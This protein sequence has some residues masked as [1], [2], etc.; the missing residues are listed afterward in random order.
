MYLMVDTTYKQA[1]ESFELN[2]NDTIH[3]GSIFSWALHSVKEWSVYCRVVPLST[4]VVNC[5]KDRQPTEVGT[6]SPSQWAEGV[7][8][9]EGVKKGI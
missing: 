2:D 1:T 8:I 4:H 6:C 9:R 3:V 7:G 5:V